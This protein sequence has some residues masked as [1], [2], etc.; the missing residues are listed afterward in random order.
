MDYIT[1]HAFRLALGGVVLLIG[2]GTVVYHFTEHW[3]WLDA[4]YF[5][6]VTLATVGYGDLVP[7]TA[8]AKLFTTI[9]IFAGVGVITSFFGLQARRRADR[10]RERKDSRR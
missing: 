10:I 7:H 2:L 4:Y 6:V 1:R 9:Y 8:F 3:S 5:S